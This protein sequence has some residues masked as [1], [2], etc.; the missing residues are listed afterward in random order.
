MLQLL[1]VLRSVRCSSMNPVVRI[2]AVI[3]RMPTIHEYVL[4]SYKAL[5]RQATSSCEARAREIEYPRAAGRSHRK[6]VPLEGS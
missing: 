1:A 3:L 6:I 2:E 5:H 4:N